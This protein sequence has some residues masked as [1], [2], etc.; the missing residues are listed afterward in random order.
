MLLYKKQEIVKVDES[1]NFF[2]V[3]YATEPDYKAFWIHKADVIEAVSKSVAA[4]VAIQQAPSAGASLVAIP[5]PL[6]P[7]TT[8]IPASTDVSPAF[9][10]GVKASNYKIRVLF[11]PH[12][13]QSIVDSFRKA[14]VV[15]PSDIRPQAVGKRKPDAQA[16]R[17]WSA[18]VTF[19]GLADAAPDGTRPVEGKANTF[20]NSQRDVVLALLQA[21]LTINDY[22]KA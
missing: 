15:L 17:S 12:A 4:R 10:A 6:K 22:A 1:T 7:V 14:G 3:H 18:T 8:I 20:I 19:E 16:P 2:K 21:G 13:E 5:K 9:I 11:P